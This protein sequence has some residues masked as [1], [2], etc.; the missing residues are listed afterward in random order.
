MARRYDKNVPPA[1]TDNEAQACGNVRISA[2]ILQN[3]DGV[4]LH[5]IIRQR[6]ACALR[7]ESNHLW[8][9]K[10]LVA[11]FFIRTLIAV[12]LLALVA[13]LVI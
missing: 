5:E 6:R 11:I 8:N 12:P 3:L 13:H 4:A 1:L 9:S 2:V 7:S 10:R